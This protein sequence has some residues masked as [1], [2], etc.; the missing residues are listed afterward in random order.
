MTNL[1]DEQANEKLH[2]L[3]GRGCWHETNPQGPEAHNLH[4]S[5]VCKHCGVDTDK[6]RNPDY[7]SD[8]NACFDA[9]AATVAKVGEDVYG[10]RLGD[11]LR[12]SPEVID[13][14]PATD[15][16][17]FVSITLAASATARERVLAMCEA[18]ARYSE[19]S[20]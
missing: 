12:V 8:L 6:V 9:Q 15:S 13:R 14:W 20:V 17:V 19:G 5:P 10:E 7:C 18:L 1:T 2:R 16:M 4:W 11:E 3:L